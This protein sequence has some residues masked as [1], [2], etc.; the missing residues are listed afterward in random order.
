MV[1]LYLLE[2]GAGYK[3]LSYL[4]MV[5]QVK[6]R[7][8][9]LV[10]QPGVGLLTLDQQLADDVLSLQESDEGGDSLGV[11]VD[12]GGCDQGVEELQRHIEDLHDLL[13]AC[14]ADSGHC[15]LDQLHEAHVELWFGQTLLKLL[16]D[17]LD[18]HLFD[19]PVGG[20]QADCHLPA[21]HCFHSTMA[22]PIIINLYL[23]LIYIS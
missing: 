4:G 11:L 2:D 8:M 20:D 19:L 5:G 12:L 17:M 22:F 21:K 14:D 7:L 15:C 23:I 1:E 13:T 9:D 6:E 3:V 18:G 10:G 16:V